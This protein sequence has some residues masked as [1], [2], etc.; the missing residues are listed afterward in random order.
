MDSEA[1]EREVIRRLDMRDARKA[2]L[3]NN[4]LLSVSNDS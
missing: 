3:K 4:M 1:Y 2:R